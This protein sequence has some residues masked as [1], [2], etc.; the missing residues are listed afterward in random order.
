MPQKVIE[1][2]GV[3]NVEFPDSMPDEAIAA[4]IKT[5][6]APPQ[7]TPPPPQSVME[8]I[9]Q[10]LPSW[11]TAAQMGG[12]G[13]G[14]AAGIPAGPAGMAAGGAFGGAGGEALYQLINEIRGGQREAD[15]NEIAKAALAGGVQGGVE[16]FLAKTAPKMLQRGA[17]SAIGNAV[18][19]SN[20]A[21]R[22]AVRSVAPQVADQMPV[23]ATSAGLLTKLKG[24]LADANVAL[25][26][27][28]NAVP[29][30]L[31]FKAQPME[32]EIAAKRAALLV[33]GKVPPGVQPQVKAYDEV[34]QWM[35]DNPKFNVEALR[36]NKQLWDSLVNYGRTPFGKDPVTEEVYRKSADI[37][38]A[39]I[40]GVFPSIGKAN[41]D[42]HAWK[43]LV[44]TLGRADL[45]DYGRI[46]SHLGDI[47]A[48][49]V[50]GIVGGPAGAGAG[51]FLRELVQTTAFQTAS[52]Q[53]RIAA[54]KALQTD[55]LPAA[56]GVLAGGGIRMMP[57]H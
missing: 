11:R 46:S 34:L 19:P 16:G 42:V 6:M 51:I 14:V 5:Q 37:I 53:A 12:A 52:V 50:G 10:Y 38:R 39:N 31:T 9:S 23:A 49:A 47:P 1:V 33:N 35:K 48:A 55:G 27:A 43:T 4:V 56:M 3:G 40:N 17:T 8:K 45:K 44:D 57:S 21:A 28:Y 26:R 24:K 2:P 41:S 32:A 20:E 13:L 29:S 22:D 54:I 25:E 18:R 15:P 7:A 36:K 30:K